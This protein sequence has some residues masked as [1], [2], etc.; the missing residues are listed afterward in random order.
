MIR[1]EKKETWKKTW[2]RKMMFCSVKFATLSR[3]YAKNTFCQ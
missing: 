2:R 1:R 3:H